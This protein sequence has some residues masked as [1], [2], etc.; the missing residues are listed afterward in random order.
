MQHKA[1]EVIINVAG[2]LGA[3]AAAFI[4]VGVFLF[5][6]GRNPIQTYFGIF[7]GAF[8]NRFAITETLVAATPIMLCAQLRLGAV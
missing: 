1:R 2:S 4:M 8:G 3:V 7:A 5:L 6:G